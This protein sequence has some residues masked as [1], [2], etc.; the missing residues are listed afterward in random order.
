MS[1]PTISVVMAVFNEESRINLTVKSI[2]QQ[3]GPELELIIVN[4]GSTDSTEAK[5]LDII[6][7]DSRVTLINQTN[8]GL[9]KALITGC[10]KARGK[11]IARQD[12]GDI[13]IQGRLQEQ[14]ETLDSRKSVVMCS[15]GTVFVA[16]DGEEF[17]HTIQSTESATLSLRHQNDDDLIGPSHHGSVTF[18]RDTYLEAGG[19]RAEFL[20]AQDLDLWTRLVEYGDHIPLQKIFYVAQTDKNSISSR[21][22]RQQIEVT[23]LIKKCCDA[24]LQRG[25]DRDILDIVRK[26]IELHSHTQ[27]SRSVSDANFYYFLG[28]CLRRENRKA[29]KKYLRKSIKLNPLNLKAILKYIF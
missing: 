29:S 9:T 16:P 26:T 12:A 13:S 1:N 28:S 27:S 17:N 15:T 8:K 20:V 3:T 11:Y 25:S 18:R 19:Y 4:D 5:I 2:L 10:K 6:A 21:K 22:R 14:V 24:R 23:K 7:S